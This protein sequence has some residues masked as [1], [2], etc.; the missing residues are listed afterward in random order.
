MIDP[1]APLAEEIA[2]IKSPPKCTRGQDRSGNPGSFY[3]AGGK[4]NPYVSALGAGSG[5]FAIRLMVGVIRMDT[6]AG[7][8]IP[9]DVKNV[10]EEQMAEFNPKFYDE[11]VPVTFADLTTNANLFSMREPETDISYSCLMATGRNKTGVA[12][13]SFICRGFKKN[14]SDADILA[15]ARDQ[16]TKDFTAIRP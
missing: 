8:F 11:T 12:V 7:K 1:S 4:V 13:A 14:A 16:I 10:T 3:K 5:G 6:S 15:M 9:L 2:S